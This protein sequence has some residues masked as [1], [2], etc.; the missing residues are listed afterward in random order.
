MEWE[1]IYNMGMLIG[2]WWLRKYAILSGARAT[3]A[4]TAIVAAIDW[5]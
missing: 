3:T 1:C 5:S 4:I 2:H